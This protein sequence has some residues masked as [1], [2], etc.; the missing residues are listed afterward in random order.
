MM[1]MNGTKK[2]C[3]PNVQIGNSRS[4]IEFVTAFK[5]LGKTIGDE[6]TWYLHVSHVQAK[7]L[8]TVTH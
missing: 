4:N 8:V 1:F 5:F 2:I 3:V 7:L 6:L